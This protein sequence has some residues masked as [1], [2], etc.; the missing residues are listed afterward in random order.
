MQVSAHNDIQYHR[1]HVRLSSFLQFI[2]HTVYYLIFSVHAFLPAGLVSDP[3]LCFRA[4]TLKIPTLEREEKTPEQHL[5]V[6]MITSA[7]KNAE[8]Q[9]RAG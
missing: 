7:T 2:A 4:Q 6:W 9:S 5:S 3:S 1:I 8:R